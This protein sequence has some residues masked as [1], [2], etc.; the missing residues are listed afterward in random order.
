MALL[1]IYLTRAPGRP[2]AARATRLG[3][4]V[5]GADRVAKYAEI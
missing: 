4:N 3:G 2:L 1:Y 5:W